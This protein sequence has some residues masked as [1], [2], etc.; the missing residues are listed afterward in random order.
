MTS[1]PAGSIDAV[2][3]YED[4]LR[5]AIDAAGGLHNL[6][7][8]AER[9]G[10][11]RQRVQQLTAHADFPESV[12]VVGRTKL[13]SGRAADDWRERQLAGRG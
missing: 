4:A 3:D 13:Y 10:V 8:L 2:T 11:T 5:A 12:L 7:T 9:W 1:Q 6:D